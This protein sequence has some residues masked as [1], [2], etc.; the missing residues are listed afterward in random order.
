M[1]LSFN[2]NFIFQDGMRDAIA[3]LSVSFS[4]DSVAS[5]VMHI[6]SNSRYNVTVADNANLGIKSIRGFF[7]MPKSPDGS[8]TSLRVLS[9]NNIS[10]VR[11][12]NNEKP[13]SS[14]PDSI[15][16]NN[17]DTLGRRNMD[18]SAGPAVNSQPINGNVS[19][20]NMP[21]GMPARRPSEPVKIK[22]LK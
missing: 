4:N 6:S 19:G 1:V 17:T 3:M 12:H 11:A 5:S 18:Q 21:Q 20:P 8:P 13:L 7:F 14:T 2:S 15:K 16:L 22:P 9:L 10:L